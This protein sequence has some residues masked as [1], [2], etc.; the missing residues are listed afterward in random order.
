MA[1]KAATMLA[2]AQTELVE[3]NAKL[4]DTGRRR[5]Q[6]LLANDATGLDAIEV[7]LA[8]LQKASVRQ[9]DRI[10]LLEA[11]AERETNE[12]RVKERQGL[13]G[14]IE[15][16][17]VERDAAGR[18][19]QNTLSKAEREFR[20][21]IRLSEAAAAAWPW[22]PSDL[23]PMLMSGATIARAVAHQLYK[24]GARPPLLGRPGELIE[25]PFPGGVCPDHR[26]R[27]LLD[28]IP[29][30]TDVLADGSRMASRI[31]R[32]G[33]AATP[34]SANGA[35]PSPPAASG[36]GETP[37]P[38]RT[39]DQAKLAALLKKQAAL[40]EDITPAGEAAYQAVV[41]EIAALS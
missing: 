34:A 40:A 18:R 29:S 17:L 32:G 41:A 26:L 25:A 27:G 36:N 12:R 22:P 3:T 5:D 4:S 35:A 31:M 16:N 9:A 6:L 21:L 8:N 10:R 2:E 23:I 28:Q 14:R 13:I 38:V 33:P 20:E 30:L 37:D 19:L 1:K 24:C 39:P 7:E 11:E 15:E